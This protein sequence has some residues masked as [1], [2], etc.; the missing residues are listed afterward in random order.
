MNALKLTAVVA[1]QCIALGAGEHRQLQSETPP[2]DNP[3]LSGCPCITPTGLSSFQISDD[4]GSGSGSG[5]DDNAGLLTVLLGDPTVLYPYPATYGRDQCSTH[6]VSQQPW[7]A[8]ADGEALADAPSWCNSEWCWVDPDNCDQQSDASSYFHRDGEDPVAYYSYHTCSADNTFADSE[9]DDQA[10][11]AE[12]SEVVADHCD[13]SVT[14]DERCPCIDTWDDRAQF[15][16]NDGANLRVTLGG[17]AASCAGT[18]DASEGEATFCAAVT[19]LG[20][21][22]ACVAGDNCAYTEFA[23]ATVYPYPLGY[24]SG[25]CAPHDFELQPSCADANSQVLADAPS[26]CQSNWCW[27]DPDNCVLDDAEAV[28]SSYFHVD[29]QDASRYYSYATCQHSNTFSDTESDP[30]ACN[31]EHSEVVADHCLTQGNAAA[32]ESCQC[33]SW[34]WAGNEAFLMDGDNAGM[35]GVSI[36]DATVPYPTGYGMAACAPHDALLPPTC[37]DADGT[38]FAD[39]PGWCGSN[40]CFVDPA[41][42]TGVADAAACA[43][44]TDASE[45]EAA[46]CATV[47]ALDDDTACAAATNCAYSAAADNAPVA[48]T[49]FHRDGE[50]PV[51][52]YSYKT[53]SHDDSFADSEDDDQACNAEHSDV[54]AEHCVPVDPFP[55]YVCILQPDDVVLGT[56]CAICC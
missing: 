31:D 26:W 2:E 21:N 33:I 54:T 46:A 36:G 50:D 40:W 41:A 3:G 37:A 51:L 23:A 4:N 29:G 52:F 34:P 45:D 56:S 47:T 24:G 44:T 18:T 25:S 14:A 17:N 8:D 11:N 7:C 42:C 38:A 15:E 32:L 20:D 48:S 35:L 12:H 5:S 9:E 55:T 43:G 53:C 10:C 16:M 30:Q 1:L 49:Y 13:V 28:A 39:A 22:S 19:A 6:D 27:V